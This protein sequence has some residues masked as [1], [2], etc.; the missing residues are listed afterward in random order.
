V[1]Q[2]VESMMVGDALDALEE[3]AARERGWREEK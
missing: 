1:L 2:T 3:S